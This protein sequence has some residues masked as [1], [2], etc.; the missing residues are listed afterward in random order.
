[1]KRLLAHGRS[2]WQGLRRPSQLDADMNEEMRF[3]IDMEAQRLA[4]AGLDPEEAARRAAVA[5]GGIEKYRGAGRDALGL[6]WL[7]GLSTDLRLGAR[8]LRKYPG[9]T[10]VGV[11]ALALA[12]GA[13]AAYL[14][15]VNDLYRPTLPFAD[16]DRLV[17]LQ[18]RDVRTGVVEDRAGWDF[19]RWRESLASLEDIGAYSALDRNLITDD[20]RSELVKGVEIS[21]SA[22]RMLRVPPLL[23]RPIVDSDERDGAAPVAVI[24][25]DL[26][27]AR[28]G[29]ETSVVGRTIRLGASTHT[30]VGVMPPGFGFPISH[31][32]WSSLHLNH[33]AHRR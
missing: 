27:Q 23:G 13:G 18:N 2:L 15:F 16:G 30:I 33:A 8:M 17:G 20:G 29:G 21:A 10:I 7:R 11:L 1:M 31:D 22:F 14:E 9:L 4:R 32:L 25:Y 19:A 24:G 3:H 28:F 5:F 26:W 6:T 12:I